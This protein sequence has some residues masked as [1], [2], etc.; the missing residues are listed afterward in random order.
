MQSNKQL[1]PNAFK[2]NEPEH[3]RK[4]CKSLFH[5]WEKRSIMNQFRSQTRFQ[6]LIMTLFLSHQHSARNT[7][8]TLEGIKKY[9]EEHYTENLSINELANLVKLSPKY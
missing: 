4:R 5:I 9:I 3:I 2:L 1:I 8:L 7:H 6:E